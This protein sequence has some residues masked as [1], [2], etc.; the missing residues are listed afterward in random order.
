MP[1]TLFSAELRRAFPW[2]P[3]STRDSGAL[4]TTHRHQQS[5]WFISLSDI[6]SDGPNKPVKPKLI[7]ASDVQK[8]LITHAGPPVSICYD[9]REVS[10]RTADL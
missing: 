2:V 4:E 7:I 6:V 3:L 1:V 8:M 9:D 10:N 5:D